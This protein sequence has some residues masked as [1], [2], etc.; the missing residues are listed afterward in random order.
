[1]KK[2]IFLTIGLLTAVAAA[3]YV[4]HV[5]FN[6]RFET[7]SEG[8]VYKSALMPPDKLETYL[9]DNK[10]NT[11]IDLL[12]PNIHDELD[13]ETQV[14]I[15]RE[16]KAVNDINKK[17]NLTIKHVNIQSAQI[18]TKE[19]LTRFYEVLDDPKNYPVLIHCYHGTG[20]AQIYSAIYRIEYENWS[21]KDA[22]EKTRLIVQ[23]LGYKSA[24]AD[25]KQK[26]DFLMHYRPRRD[27]ADA[28][29]NT[30]DK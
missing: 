29:V 9:V 28:T 17:H 16:D 24:F 18:P 19:T 2:K 23:G 12:H 25:G 10:I 5:N 26:G 8:K 3:Y 20:R 11:V 14:E 27:G 22:R 30:L 13:P 7:I 4:W 21:N 6:Y 15:D 1:M